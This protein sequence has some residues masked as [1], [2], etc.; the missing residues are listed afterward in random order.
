MEAVVISLLD[1][2]VEYFFL[3]LQI[4]VIITDIT[5]C[6]I[7]VFW[8]RRNPQVA[9]MW[10]LVM[11]FLPIIGFFAY[12]FLGRHLYGSRIFNKKTLADSE[13]IDGADEQFRRFNAQKF[14]ETFRDFERTAALL[15]N[16]DKSI[17]TNNNSVEPFIDG[18]AIFNSIINDIKNAKHHIHMEF[19]IIR[20]DELGREIIKI[21][22]EKAAEGVEVRVIFDA[23][24]TYSIHKKKFFAPIINAGGDV[25]IFFPLKIPF[26]NTRFHFRDHRKI[27]VIDGCIGYIG[28]FNIGEEYLGRGRMGYWRD[29]HLRIKGC[30][31]MGLQSRFTMDWNY[32]A[33]DKPLVINDVSCSPYYPLDILSVNYG[34][35]NVQIASS[36]P[37]SPE[38]AIYSGYISLISHAKES[39]YIHSPYFIPDETMLTDLALAAKSGIDVRVVIPCKPDHP[40]VYWANHSYLGD[41][42]RQG[43][44]GYTYNDG[45]I[46]SKTGI[47]DGFAVTVGTANWDI[48]SFKLNFETNAFVYDSEFGNKMKEIYLKELETNCTEI[49]LE[50][51]NS[52][53]LLMKIKEGISRLVSPLL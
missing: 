19:F 12:L 52:R 14:P 5:A 50:D 40:F 33:K 18:N 2:I 51:Y 34:N 10:L 26:L 35:A 4:L 27:L 53:P 29:T 45:F 15:L 47:F 23:A 44:R 3:I 48:R 16:I 20:D 22:G 28:G 24:G 7:V 31:V 30:G 36:G 6:V 11:A 39:I 46:H 37:D 25:R 41:L 9:I 43:V 38:K 17:I 1:L 32:A 21:L 8:E 13:L 42:I 49:T